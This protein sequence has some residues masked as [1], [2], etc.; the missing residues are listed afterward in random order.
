M[1]RKRHEMEEI[2]KIKSYES[3]KAEVDAVT[4]LEEEGK[5]RNTNLDDLK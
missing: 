4:R 5:E 2:Q 1:E 3:A